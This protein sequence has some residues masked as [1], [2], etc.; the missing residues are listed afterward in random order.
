MKNEGNILP[1]DKTQNI[2]VTGPT[3]HSLTL[4]NGAWTRTWQGTDPKWNDESK[5]T[6]YEA[7]Q[8]K[9]EQVSFVEG[10]GLDALKDIQAVVQK[11][12]ESD[13]IVVCLGEKPST[14]KPGDIHSLNIE[15]AQVALVKELAK[16][17]KPIVLVLVENR[18]RIVREIEPLCRAIL[19]AYQPSE[20]G[21]AALADIIFGQVNPSGKLPITYPRYTNTLLTYDHK[22]TD[23]LDTDFSEKAFNPQW[24]FGHGCPTP[25]MNILI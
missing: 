10:S 23:R 14:E 13:V 24:E 22:Y 20:N 7:L 25:T 3:A 19:M 12:N 6:I 4:V 11:S 9:G 17:G 18:P 21:T 2:L 8:Q 1:L 16:T 5:S 15:K